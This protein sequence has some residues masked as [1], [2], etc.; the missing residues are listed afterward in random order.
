MGCAYTYCSC[1]F[2]AYTVCSYIIT[3]IIIIIII[4]SL[5]VSFH[6]HFSWWFF[7]EVW[8]TSLFRYPVDLNSAVVW[9]F[10]ILPLTSSLPGLFSGPLETVPSAPSTIGII[11][12]LMFPRVFISLT[13]WK[14]L[15]IFTFIFISLFGPLKEIY[16]LVEKFFP[17]C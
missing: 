2:C 8:V 10:F 16:S 7:T 12:N 14:Y 1:G 9:I 6:S 13:K 17:S 5:F 3:I 11:V 15:S 4:V